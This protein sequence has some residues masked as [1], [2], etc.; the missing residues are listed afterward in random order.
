VQQRPSQIVLRR[1]VAELGG[2]HEE[3]ERRDRVELELLGGAHVMPTL[4]GAVQ[5][6]LD[7]HAKIA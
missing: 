2:T 6:G 5:P 4:A 3:L 1:R 7:G